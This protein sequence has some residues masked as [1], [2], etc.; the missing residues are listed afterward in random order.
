MSEPLASS[1]VEA[2]IWLCQGLAI[3]PGPSLW[4]SIAA[5][6]PRTSGLL[7]NGT[8]ACLASLPDCPAATFPEEASIAEGFRA[9][10]RREFLAGRAC[11]RAAMEALGCPA[12]PIGMKADGGPLWP[13]GLAGSISHTSDHCLAVVG[14][15]ERFRSIGVDLEVAGAVSPSVAAVV[16]TDAELESHDGDDRLTTLFA[17]KEAFIKA[18]RPLAGDL[19]DFRDIEVGL[20]PDG[21]SWCA[22]LV[23]PVAAARLGRATLTGRYRRLPGHVVALAAVAEDGGAGASPACDQAK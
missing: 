19:V 1:P 22:R 5:A 20:L 18:C 11:A 7:P 14:K 21:L 10:R 8:A 3:E 9:K 13:E 16:L 17:I 2:G 6:E 23:D 15:S 4:A 12:Q